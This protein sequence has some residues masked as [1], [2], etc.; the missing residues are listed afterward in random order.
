VLMAR[1]LA[2]RGMLR[3]DAAA[4]ITVSATLQTFAQIVFAL[5]LAK[6]ARELLLGLPGLLYWHFAARGSAAPTVSP[7]LKYRL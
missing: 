4:A 7:R 3:Q 6:R 1:H 5:S 2:Q